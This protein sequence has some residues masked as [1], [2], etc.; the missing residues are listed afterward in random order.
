MREHRA[1]WVEQSEVPS[2]LH[3]GAHTHGRAVLAFACLPVAGH[4][5]VL[6]GLVVSWT[7][8]VELAPVLREHLEAITTM[9][10]AR[11]DDLHP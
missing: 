4:Q 9:V 10:G 8:P 2:V 3:E 7:D 11:L 6:G 1:V 5:R